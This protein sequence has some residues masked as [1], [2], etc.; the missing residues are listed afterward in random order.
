[1]K[2]TIHIMNQAP[3]FTKWATPTTHRFTRFQVLY[4]KV[5]VFLHQALKV[6]LQLALVDTPYFKVL[7]HEVKESMYNME[8]VVATEASWTHHISRHLLQIERL[9]LHHGWNSVCKQIIMDSGDQFLTGWQSI[10]SEAN[11][12]TMRGHC[13]MIRCGKRGPKF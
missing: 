10:P 3:M 5:N 11:F 2:T 9:H 13:F 7:C 12:D 6:C 8:D 1:M 4:C